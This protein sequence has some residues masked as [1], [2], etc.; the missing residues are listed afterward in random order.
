MNTK[1][2]A[3]LAVALSIAGAGTA[4]A[5]AKFGC[6]GTNPTA[7]TISPNLTTKGADRTDLGFACMMWQ[8]FVAL[9]WPALAGQRG[10][11]DTNAKFGAAGP[12]VWETYKTAD[13]TFLPGA[14]NPGPWNQPT[15]MA[16]LQA[17]LA[18]QVATGAVRHLTRTSKV[19]RAVLASIARNRKLAAQVIDSI[20]QAGGGTLYDL[21]GNPVYYEIAMNQDQYTFIVQNGLYNANTQA[22]FAQKQTFALPAGKTQYG[23]FGSI[24]LKAAWKVLSAT[25]QNSGRFHTIQALL[26]G[27]Q[28]PVTVGLV[29]FHVFIPDVAQGVWATFAQIDNAPIVKPATSGTFN[30]FNPNCTVPGTSTP[31]PVNV[32]DADPGQVLQVNPDNPS[33]GGLNA[34][35]Q[36]LIKAYDAS[37]PWQF[38]KI[39]DV[40]WSLQPVPLARLKRPLIA[41]LPQGSPNHPNVVNAV[42]ET[43]LQKPNVGC[44]SCHSNATVANSGIRSISAAT[45]Y[46]FM[47]GEASV[48]AP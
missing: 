21:N 47:F 45:G 36:G 9:N 33:V 5:Q 38:Y 10:M 17:G 6:G 3:C 26:G 7:P 34:Y 30:F 8:N 13:Q 48:P 42:L 12:T 35:M 16:T 24:E 22:G 28:T 31:C 41:P 19:S 25:E 1:A 46:S 15:L 14:R 11:P 39:V 4:H 29:G 18:E 2:I 43:F 27:S 32:K 37:T 44:L 20:T 23:S 40:Q